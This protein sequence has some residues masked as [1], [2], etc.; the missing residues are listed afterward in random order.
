MNIRRS[1]GFLNGYR[2]GLPRLRLTH[3]NQIATFRLT[4]AEHR[5]FVA[6]QAGR[7]AA[8]AVNAE[9]YGHERSSTIE[10]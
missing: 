7:L 4:T 6:Y 1:A 5:M 9:E 2:E 3:P 8:S 10:P